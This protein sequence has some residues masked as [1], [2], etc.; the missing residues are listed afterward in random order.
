M[1]WQPGIITFLLY[2]STY[3]DNNIEINT[4]QEETVFPVISFNKCLVEY[5]TFVLIIAWDF[6]LV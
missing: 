1:A 3:E 6:A 5:A 4:I 2:L